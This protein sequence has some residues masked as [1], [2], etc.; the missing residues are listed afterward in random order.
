MTM[1]ASR[2]ATERAAFTLPF[3]P[4]GMHLLDVGC[5]LR[6]WLPHEP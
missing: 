6:I 2:V 1:M 3:L 5:G 4:D